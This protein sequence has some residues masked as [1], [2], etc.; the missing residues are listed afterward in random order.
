MVTNFPL[1]VAIEIKQ[2]KNNKYA[3]IDNNI[4]TF[5]NRQLIKLN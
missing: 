5:N 4:D 2:T 1:C 3:I